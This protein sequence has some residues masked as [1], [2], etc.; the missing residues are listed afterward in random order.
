M[1]TCRLM[2]RWHPHFYTPGIR[3]RFARRW[4]WYGWCGPVLS[5]GGWIHVFW[6]GRFRNPLR[7]C[8]KP[9]RSGSC[10]SSSTCI[11][12]SRVCFRGTALCGWWKRP[13]FPWPSHTPAVHGCQPFREGQFRSWW[14]AG[15]SSGFPALP[16]WPRGCSAHHMAWMPLVWLIALRASMPWK[17]WLWS[18]YLYKP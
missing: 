13:G 3:C 12:S 7:N 6:S 17:E 8:H 10:H 5:P 4:F 2:Y 14:Y 15:K 16:L 18:C 11:Y 1:S 9:N